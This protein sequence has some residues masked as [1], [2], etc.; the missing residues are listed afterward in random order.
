MSDKSNSSI[1]ASST[2]RDSTLLRLDGNRHWWEGAQPLCPLELYAVVDKSRN[3]WYWFDFIEGRWSGVLT[4][5]TV[6]KRKS[7]AQK[8]AEAYNAHVETYSLVRHP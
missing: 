2:V 1:A 6:T 4:Q 8:T 3:D 7:F 5:N